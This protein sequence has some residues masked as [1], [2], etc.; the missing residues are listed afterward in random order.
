MFHGTRL[1]QDMS[2]G[3]TTALSSPSTSLAFL[4]SP[5]GWSLL[6]IP[7]KPTGASLDTTKCWKTAKTD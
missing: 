2:P 5:R 6:A 3:A 7:D 1:G 4:P